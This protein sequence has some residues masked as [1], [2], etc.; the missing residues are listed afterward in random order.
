[1]KTMFIIA[2]VLT[3]CMLFPA[4]IMHRSYQEGEGEYHLTA[5]NALIG[6]YLIIMATILC[7]CI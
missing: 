3:I 7:F 1:M 6:T 5:R 4:Y 2:A